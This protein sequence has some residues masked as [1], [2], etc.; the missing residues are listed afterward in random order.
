MIAKDPVQELLKGYRNILSVVEYDSEQVPCT[1]TFIHDKTV[2]LMLS[3][4]DFENAG[5]D[6]SVIY[7]LTLRIEV[8]TEYLAKEERETV[9]N[10]IME[11]VT[12]L[13]ADE[14]NVNSELSDFNIDLVFP[15]TGD[16]EIDQDNI[17]S[18]VIKRKDFTLYVEQLP[19]I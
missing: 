2:Y 11:Q 15:Q 16:R 14:S 18:L 9:A 13:I 7:N 12:P 1:V 4:P 3:I 8:V 5:T 17:S 10:K 6:D 19:E